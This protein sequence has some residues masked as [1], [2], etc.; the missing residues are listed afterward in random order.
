[1]IRWCEQG[2]QPAAVED[3]DAEFEAYQGDLKGFEVR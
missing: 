2:P 3:V 1:M